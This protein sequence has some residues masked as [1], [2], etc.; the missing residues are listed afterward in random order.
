MP[1]ILIIDDDAFFVSIYS[2]EFKLQGFE[3]LTAMSGEEALRLASAQKPDIILLDLVMPRMDGFQVIEALKA[4]SSTAAT[5]IC[6]LTNLGLQQDI[7]RCMKLG[8][9]AYAIKAQSMPKEMV[10]R[11][12][13]I[14]GE[15]S[16]HEALAMGSKEGEKGDGIV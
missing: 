12:K 16:S 1:S 10:E 15:G 8:V 5:P 11:V 3:V 14:L 6:I 4:D 7:D 2:E 13:K 9:A